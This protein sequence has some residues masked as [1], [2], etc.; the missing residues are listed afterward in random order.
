MLGLLI[1]RFG[2][3]GQGTH[4]ALIFLRLEDHALLVEEKYYVS[5]M[6]NCRLLMRICSN[7]PMTCDV[8]MVYLTCLLRFHLY[9]YGVEPPNFMKLPMDSS[10]VTQSL[11]SLL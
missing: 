11:S 6:E 10:F 5:G 4:N 3:K 9:I 2:P 1:S 8:P 7:A